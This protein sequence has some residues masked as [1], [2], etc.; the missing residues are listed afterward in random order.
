MDPSGSTTSQPRSPE[1][2]APKTWGRAGKMA[3]WR[4]ALGMPAWLAKLG[5]PKTH[6][7]VKGKNKLF[8]AVL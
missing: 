8:T 4:K 2:L 7:K 1:P 3:P 5:P 6:I